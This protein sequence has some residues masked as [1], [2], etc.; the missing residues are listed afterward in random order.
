MASDVDVVMAVELGRLLGSTRLPSHAEGSVFVGAPGLVSLGSCGV[1]G[2][3]GVCCG[4]SLPPRAYLACVV[5]AKARSFF[6]LQIGR[7]VAA[8][9]A[10]AGSR[11]VCWC[12]GLMGGQDLRGGGVVRSPS[13]AVGGLSSIGEASF[14]SSFCSFMFAAG[15]GWGKMACRDVAGYAFPWQPGTHGV[16]FSSSGPFKLVLVSSVSVGCWDC[17]FNCTA[18]DFCGICLGRAGARCPAQAA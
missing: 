18:Q 9:S 1:S 2:L 6:D 11:E 8:F 16:L 4:A 5:A 3:V 13:C 10:L 7:K 15:W 17:S 12:D 14:V